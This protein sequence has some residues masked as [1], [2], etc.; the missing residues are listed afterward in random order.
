MIWEK[1][2]QAGFRMPLYMHLSAEGPIKNIPE[3]IGW[4]PNNWLVVG[5]RQMTTVYNSPV[6]HENFTKFFE[7]KILASNETSHKFITALEKVDK[8]LL[9]FCRK[10]NFT[11]YEAASSDILMADLKNFIELFGKKFSV[12]SFPILAGNA[13]QALLAKVFSRPIS[14]DELFGLITGDNLGEYTQE[15]LALLHITNQIND[16]RLGKLFLKNRVI[17][18]YEI[19]KRRA[20]CEL[21]FGI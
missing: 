14:R 9:E 16:L 18:I 1:L 8:E 11:D 19:F 15:R 10:T 21:F 3:I 7:E 20:F 17:T 2:I 4:Q 12:Y 13:I 6:D 5:E